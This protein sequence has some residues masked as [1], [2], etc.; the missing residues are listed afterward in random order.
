MEHGHVPW[1]TQASSEAHEII[2]VP[3]RRV[4]FIIGPSGTRIRQ[5]KEQTK[6]QVHIEAAANGTEKRSVTVWGS[7]E[8]VAA[9]VHLI[10][11]CLVTAAN[12]ES[13][14][15]ALQISLEIDPAL[16][17]RVIGRGGEHIRDMQTRSGAHVQIE[18]EDA[19][20]Y[21]PPIGGLRRVLI[22]GPEEAREKARALLDRYLKGEKLADMQREA[23]LASPASSAAATAAGA[24][25]AAAA[26]ATPNVTTEVSISDGALTALV[27]PAQ[28]GPLGQLQASGVTIFISR[29]RV[30]TSGGSGADAVAAAAAS[31]TVAGEKR[32]HA[33]VD[34]CGGGG[35]EGSSS[36][37][38]GVRTVRL[39][40]NAMGVHG[41]KVLLAGC[42]AQ[43]AAAKAAS[44]RTITTAEEALYT[45]Y[46][47]YY[48][49]AGMAYAAPAKLWLDEVDAEAARFKMWANY[50]SSSGQ[51]PDAASAPAPPQAMEMVGPVPPLADPPPNY[52]A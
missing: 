16:V 23:S 36:S 24:A 8:A 3:D 7:K 20:G 2:E 27:D 10:R 40:G 31:G 32:P 21:E 41:V 1:S 11:E 18:R 44:E 26:A 38:R 9:C 12:T 6:A 46:S 50:Y 43:A 48:E 13:D 51:Q 33:A 49:R 42:E 5:I 25:A 47:P 52:S 15:K 29:A 35:G 4:G 19:P 22:S 45:Y 17:G 37:S 28:P 34:G 30:V 14:K 39:C